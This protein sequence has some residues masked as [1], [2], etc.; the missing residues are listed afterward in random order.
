MRAP[1]PLPDV[2][3]R[4]R[5][6]G[7]TY[8]GSPVCV[9]Q[10]PLV[11]SADE[12]R[13][14]QRILPRFHRIIQKVRSALLADLHLGPASL[15]ARIGVPLAELELAA[16]DPGFSS[17]APF[18]RVDAYVAEGAPQFLELNAESP[19]GM[20]YAAALDAVFRADPRFAA[21][22]SILPIAPSIATIRAI[23]REWG[24]RHRRLQIAIV[25]FAGVGTAPEFELLSH[26]FQCAGLPTLVT[27]PGR[28]TFDGDRLRA[29]GTAIDVVFRRFLVRDVV[30]RASEL[31]PLLAA[32]RAR[33]VCMINSLRTALLHNK[34]VFALL[35]DPLFPLTPLER[36]FVARHIPVT[37]LLDDAGR[38]RARPAQAEWVLKPTDGHGGRGVVLGWQVSRRDWDVALATTAPTI[39]QRRA[40][41]RRSPFVDARDGSTRNLLADLAPFLVRGRLAGFLCRV[42]PTELANVTTGGA[43]QVPVFVA[44]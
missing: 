42:S 30:T 28:L 24:Y 8:A 41:A 4:I 18:A 22:R 35:H 27:T 13:V 32:Y 40:P 6:A 14:W 19:A 26:A 15:A 5:A 9:H 10:T 33:R 3:E 44:Q 20:G 25:D 23:A 37:Y 38:E 31:R 17:V 39:L 34:G 7:A 1:S 2:L 11:L 29:D 21:L 12:V 36:A 16:I 43:T